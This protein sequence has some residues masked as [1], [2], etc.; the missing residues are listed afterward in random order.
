LSA[1]AAM[2]LVL[3]QA[4]PPVLGQ[5]AP[6]TPPS[7]EG[8]PVGSVGQDYRIGPGD[9]L[10]ITV[11]GYDDLTQTVVVQPT[12]GFV[13]PLIGVVPASESTPGEV[14]QKLA[15]RLAK[16]LIRDPKVT[17]VVQDYRSKVVFALGEI[18]RPGTYPLAG[19]TTLVELLSRAGPLS[20]GAASEVIV[21][22]PSAPTNRPVL[23]TDIQSSEGSGHAP[24]AEILHVELRD[25]QEGQFQKNLTLRPNDTIF[26]PQAARVFVSGE[27][28]NAGA[29][30]FSRGLTVRQAVSLAGGFTPEASTGGVRVVREVAGRH[31]TTKVK[32]DDPVR[33]GDTIVVK[34]RMF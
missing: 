10:R 7:S 28:K 32:L 8:R 9:I 4:A 20:P 14:E 25:L 16:G 1:F 2:L 23:P 26:V 12:G 29:F 15:K 13:F 27:V 18:T 6:P 31:V 34:T 3:G 11:Y 22:R 19:Q 24:T 21:V 17:V 33:P 30:P 5:G